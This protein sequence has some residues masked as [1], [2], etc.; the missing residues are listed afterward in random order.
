[1]LSFLS[2]K[3]I[4]DFPLYAFLVGFFFNLIS[5]ATSYLIFKNSGFVAVSVAGLVFNLVLGVPLLEKIFELEDLKQVHSKNFFHKNRL[6][7][8]FIIYYF[9]GI[10]LS[11][12]VIGFFSPQVIYSKEYFNGDFSKVSQSQLDSLEMSSFGHSKVGSNPIKVSLK[13][14]TKNYLLLLISFFLSLFYGAGAIFLILLNASFFVNNFFS[15]MSGNLNNQNTLNFVF[16][17]VLLFFYFLPEFLSYLMG[18]ISGGLL[19]HAIFSMKLK[20]ENFHKIFYHSFVIFIFS[21]I[22]LL[23]SGFLEI[24]FVIPLMSLENPFF[25]I[26]IIFLF[27]VFFSVLIYLEILRKKKSNIEKRI[28][29]EIN[30]KF[31]D[32]EKVFNNERR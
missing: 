25:K 23:I 15:F 7:F 10:V 6:L 21:L 4:E 28:S 5:Y 9:L 14:F 17:L 13:I 26:L 29:I 20:K 27:F 8:D 32:F 19:S 30:H 24:I 31:N 11:L 2:A 1:M 12:F 22:L 18:T 16:Y 3:K